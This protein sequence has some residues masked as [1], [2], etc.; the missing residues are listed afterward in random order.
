MPRAARSVAKR[1]RHKK[2]LQ[3]AKGYRGRRH[4]VFKLAK[5]AVLKAGQHAYTDRRKKKS[6]FRELWLTRINAAARA[7][8]VSY[9]DLAHGLKAHG[10]EIDRKILAE[11]ALAHPETFKAIVQEATA[12]SPSSSSSS[13][14]SR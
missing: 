1:H 9:R 5:E 2:W 10:I 13:R 11:L 12:P 6:K 14:K 4:T 7:A 3:R 8:G